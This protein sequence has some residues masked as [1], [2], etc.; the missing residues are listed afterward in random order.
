MAA[1]E[2]EGRGAAGVEVDGAQRADPGG[3][4]VD[5]ALVDRH[6]QSFMCG[7]QPGEVVRGE[8]YVQIERSEGE[9]GDIAGNQTRFADRAGQMWHISSIGERGRDG[10]PHLD[11]PFNIF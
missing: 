10:K 3:Q 6:L 5:L 4:A 9:G 2:A 7:T 11:D 1:P 8:A